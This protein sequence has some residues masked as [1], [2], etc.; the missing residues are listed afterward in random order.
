MGPTWV[1]SA[2]DGPHVG[3]MNLAIW[4]PTSR[5]YGMSFMSTNSD[6]ILSHFL[7]YYVQYR[8]IL[9]HVLTTR[10]CITSHMICSQSCFTLCVVMTSSVIRMMWWIHAIYLPISSRVASPTVDCL[11]L[12]FIFESSFT[13]SNICLQNIHPTVHSWRYNIP[14]PTT[15][16]GFEPGLIA[17]SESLASQRS[18]WIFGQRVT[19]SSE[20]LTGRLDCHKGNI[21]GVIGPSKILIYF[22]D[23]WLLCLIV[24]LPISWRV[25]PRHWSNCE[26][27]SETPLTDR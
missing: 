23:S 26:V 20:W 9:H 22:M 27:G 7:Y 15:P 16:L 14:A 10:D 11:I 25:A 21:W 4:D 5:P 18:N 6:Y 3:P 24:T 17:H 19:P 1:L 8:V 12:Y 13:T 2:P